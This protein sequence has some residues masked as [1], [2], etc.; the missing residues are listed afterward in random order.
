MRLDEELENHFENSTPIKI[1]L[2]QKLCASGVH[3]N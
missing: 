2:S 1:K 3:T